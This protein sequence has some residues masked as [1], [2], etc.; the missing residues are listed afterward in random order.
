VTNCDGPS[1]P[2]SVSALCHPG[3]VPD[4]PLD[5]LTATVGD[6]GAATGPLH[7]ILTTLGARPVAGPAGEVRLRDTAVRAA[8][9]DAAADWERTGFPA[10]SRPVGEPAGVAR[11]L[12]LAIELLSPSSGTRVRV[13]GPSRLGERAALLGLPPASTSSAGGAA[14]LIE[15]ADGWFALNLARPEDVD[16]V[17]ALV[18]DAV[19]DDPWEAVRRWAAGRPTG[20]IESRA[21]L[22][23]LPAGVL[24]PPPDDAHPWTVRRLRGAGRSAPDPRNGSRRVVNL[25]SLWAAPLCAQ[26][27]AR[28]GHTVVDVESPGRPDGARGGTPDF[29]RHLHAGHQRIVL[30][31]GSSAGRRE[32]HDRLAGADVVVTASR[33][34]ALR[35]LGALAPERPGRDQ[36]WIAITAHGLEDGRVGFGDDAAVA[37]GLVAG[38]ADGPPWFAGDAVADPLGGLAAGTAALACLAAGGS[39]RVEVALREVASFA[40][41]TG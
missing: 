5:G 41:R 17:P 37:G 12:A 11:A 36:V 14:R 4:A 39:W 22:L 30:D 20:E 27:L 29:Y 34:E 38:A 32:L 24:R 2:R 13:D 9:S 10:T 21:A 7:R 18:A 23:G 15:A 40:A 19:G 26:L 33:H 28:A 8:T 3:R 1:T 25:G 6:V 16:L 31:L 35:R